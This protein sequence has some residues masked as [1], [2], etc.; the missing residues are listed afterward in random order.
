VSSRASLRARTIARELARQ[1]AD[2]LY[3]EGDTLPPV[4]TLAAEQGV[5]R[6]TVRRAYRILEEHGVVSSQRGAGTL[7]RRVQTSALQAVIRAAPSTADAMRTGPQTL[8]LATSEGTPEKTP[9]WQAVI[10]AFQQRHPQLT[11]R[12]SS[13]PP[14]HWE[15]DFSA[16]PDILVAERSRIRDLAAREWLLD[17]EPWLQDDP[18][19]QEDLVGDLHFTCT[20]PCYEV[21]VC[22]GTRV[23][24]LNTDAIPPADQEALRAEWSV[25]AILAWADKTRQKCSEIVPVSVPQPYVLLYACGLDVA[26]HGN[27]HAN[28]GRLPDILAQ[29]AA[30]HAQ[31]T[32]YTEDAFAYSRGETHYRRVLAGAEAM[33]FWHT[34]AI[35]EALAHIRFPWAVWPFPLAPEQPCWRQGLSC[36]VSK[37]CRHPEAA[38]EFVRVLT[39]MEGQGVLARGKNNIP[40]LRA[41][42]RS[43]AFSKPPPSGL[44]TVVRSIRRT[45]ELEGQAPRAFTHAN[46]AVWDEEILA[47]LHQRQSATA[48]TERIATRV[49]RMIKGF[50]L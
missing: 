38:I 2:G 8:L 15:A 30:W 32:F 20:D 28:I 31:Y 41:A 3:A 39:G 5:S 42:A 13:A 22:F 50:G 11:V 25:R 27:L 23:V 19:L 43:P 9:I 34:F 37:Q 36:A 21:P 46:L 17:L 48:T 24:F 33:C 40:V 16:L 12:L 7:V 49:G 44:D 26:D 4:R 1:I 14:A 47:F 6:E 45:R 18:P 10:R 29:L 35:P